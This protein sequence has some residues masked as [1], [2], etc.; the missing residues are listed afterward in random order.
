MTTKNIHSLKCAWLSLLAS[1]ALLLLS[2]A[3]AF[4]QSMN[5]NSLESLFGET[6]TASAT[7]LPQRTTEVP[8]DMIVV[9][10]DDIRRSGARDVPGVLSHVAGVDVM[11]WAGEAVD[12]SIRGYDQAYASRTLVL[13]DGRQVYADYYG[14]IPWSALPVEMKAIRQ[15]EIVKGPNAALFGFNAVGGVI[16]IIT[17]NPR[18][19]NVNAASAFSGTQ[20]QNGLS[21]V[22]TIGLNRYGGLRLSGGYR[23]GQD[24]TTIM[25]QGANMVSRAGNN[26][27]AVDLDGVIILNESMELGIEASHTKAKQNEESPGYAIQYSR[28]ET[29]SLKTQLFADTD[30]GLIKLAAYGNWI[31]WR[32]TTEPIFG[33][34]TLDNK[35]YVVKVE[36]AFDIGSDHNFRIAAEYRHNSVNTTPT[37]GS[38]VFYDEFSGSAMWHWQIVPG[39]SL[40]N[41][42]RIDHLN[43]G[44]DGNIP[45]GYPFANTSWNHA[46]DEFSFN[47]GLVWKPTETDT[48]RLI[49]GRGVQLPS[50]VQSGAML[51]NSPY[52]Q[53]SG[54]PD[55]RMTAA[56][57]FEFSWNRKL[58]EMD[59][60]FQ[61]ALFRQHTVNMISISGKFIYTNTGVYVTPTNVGSSEASGGEISLKGA[62]DEVWRWSFDYR[63]EYIDDD[64]ADSARGPANLINYQDTTP[65][66]LVKAGIG[67]HS[68]VWEADAYLRFQSATMGIRQT[69][70]FN[71]GLVSVD[72][73]AN[74]DAR[75]AYRFNN[76]ATVEIAGQNLL[77]DKQRQT[78]GP[79][80]E[81]R[82][83]ATLSVR[84]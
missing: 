51:I 26:R 55:L 68:D 35:V 83:F 61:I 75:L 76:W 62:I 77:Q 84:G 21:A 36:D 67:W 38:S 60:E 29:N 30:A 73:F 70:M 32:G 41:A 50:L 16:N 56:T 58:P 71:Y 82:I 37:A 74:I 63:A 6:V 33:D 78:S 81:R 23:T 49:A 8:A 10:A 22:A 39:L 47:S 19:D 24:Y 28:Y 44:R 25:S 18:Y 54:S 65:Q 27:A 69:S 12:V 79:I 72:A 52:A 53:V 14:F 7:G 42:L 40:T 43:L 4:A 46:I 66:H 45:N 15:I 17:Y 2:A 3:S 11:Q 48:F 20:N 57:N 1:G 31:N 34:F 9:T 13:I 64:F 5:Y 59:A 80:V